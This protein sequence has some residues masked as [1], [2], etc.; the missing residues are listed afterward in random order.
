VASLEFC[1][2]QPLNFFG[3]R[4]ALVPNAISPFLIASLNLSRSTPR[5][6][7]RERKAK[8][9]AKKAKLNLLVIP[10]NSIY[11]NQPTPQ[12]SPASTQCKNKSLHK[13]IYFHRFNT[14]RHRRHGAQ[15]LTKPCRYHTPAH[16]P[17]TRKR[18]YSGSRVHS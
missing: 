6:H 3:S 16:F 4:F 11:P 15:S 5:A 9:S 17:Q 7:T 8:G 18:S 10:N 2:L 14:R 13:I 1:Q 12:I